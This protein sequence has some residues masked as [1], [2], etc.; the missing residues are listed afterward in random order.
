MGAHDKAEGSAAFEPAVAPHRDRRPAGLPRG[1]VLDHPGGAEGNAPSSRGEE[2]A[3]V[4]PGVS[5]P[6]R[7]GLPRPS[8]CVGPE[9]PSPALRT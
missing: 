9:T 4:G 6:T 8:G 5:E 7:G 2:Q 3:V 1:R